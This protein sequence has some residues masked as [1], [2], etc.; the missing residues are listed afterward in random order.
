MISKCCLSELKNNPSYEKDYYLK[1]SAY[2]RNFGTMLVDGRIVPTPTKE[3]WR[4]IYKNSL[5][6]CSKCGEPCD[7]VVE[8]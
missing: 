4:D 2:S 8:P 7:T 6:V 3:P 5:F 1:T